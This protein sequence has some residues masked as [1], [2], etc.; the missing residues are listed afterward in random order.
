MRTNGRNESL[1]RVV[2]A[3]GFTLIELLVVIAIIAIL[4]ALLLPAL[5]AAKRKAKLAQCQSNF[6]QIMIACNVYANSYDDYYPICKVGSGN[7]GNSFN[8]ITSQH[9]TQYIVANGAGPNAPLKTGIQSGV[10]DC[11][12]HLYETRAAGNGK[13]FFCPAFPDSSGITPAV[14]ST[15]LFMSTPSTTGHPTAAGGVSTG[16]YSVFGTMLFNPRRTDAWGTDNNGTGGNDLRA[17]PKT[18]SQWK[19]PTDGGPAPDSFT[20]KGLTTTFA[21]TLPGAR[22]LFATDCLAVLDAPTSFSQNSFSHFPSQGFDVLFTDG[23][24]SFVQSVQAFNF[25]STGQLAGPNT[26]DN[27]APPVPQDYDAIYNWLENGD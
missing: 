13:V 11:L 2:A 10:F 1:S 27:E 12:G 14:Y 9:Y 15:P 16:G 21:Y 8:H 18:S 6:H 26:P 20:V 5:A 24:V 7:G 19:G 23:S 22:H 17:F 3:C 4:A 25:I